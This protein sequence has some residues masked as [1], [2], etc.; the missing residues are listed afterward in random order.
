VTGLEAVSTVRRGTHRSR[1]VPS[2]VHEPPRT[3]RPPRA[4]LRKCITTVGS[5]VDDRFP[6]LRSALVRGL[7]IFVFHEV[8]DSPSPLQ[9][10]TRAFVSPDL[11][12]EQVQW[13]R[14]RFT[15]IKPTELEQ[16]GGSGTLPDDAAMLTFDDA[17]AGVFRVALPL[18]KAMRIPAVCF[19]NMATVMGDPDLSAVGHYEQASRPEKR[20]SVPEQVGIDAS[21]TILTRVRARYG[22]SSGFREF[23]G[24]TADPS[25][26]RKVANDSSLVWFGSHLYHHWDPRHITPE[27]YERSLDDNLE[28]LATYSNSLPMF[29]PPYGRAGGHEVSLSL[30]L[31]YRVVLTGTGSQNMDQGSNVLDRLELPAWRSTARDWWYASHRRRLLGW[32]LPRAGVLQSAR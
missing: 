32:V 17:W 24:P 8:T 18:L 19:L 1:R 3:R 11:F 7:T 4:A 30:R 23:Q 22:A 5:R 25:D 29:A 9:R 16:L 15:I 2:T 27:L 10:H 31:G 26:L 21:E 12:V 13:L 20:R 28:A 14:Q 6:S